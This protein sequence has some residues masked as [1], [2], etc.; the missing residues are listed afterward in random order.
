[1]GIIARQGIKQ[2]IV[3]YLGI[4][5]GAVNILFIYPK[6]L[7]GEQYGFIQALISAAKIFLPFVLL[8]SMY[9]IVRFFPDFKDKQNGHN[10]Y[11]PFILLW[12]NVGFTLFAAIFIGFQKEIF[13]IFKANQDMVA[14]YGNYLLPILYFLAIATILTKYI[15]NF[16]RIAIPSIF[17]DLFLK[18]GAP[19]LCILF[20]FQLLD[21]GNL[22]QGYAW[23][24]G[25]IVIALVYYTYYLGQLFLKLDFKKFTRE[26]L[27][28]IGTYASYGILGGL[29]TSIIPHIDNLMVASLMDFE[30]TAIYIIPNFITSAIDAPRRAIVGIAAPLIAESWKKNDLKHIQE[31]YQK[32]SLN[33][34][35]VGVFLLLLA[36]SSIDHLYTLIPEGPNKTNYEAG[37]YIVLI[38][39]LSKVF[40]MVTGVNSEIIG[41][42]KYFRFNFYAIVLL[43]VFAI[44]AN[45]FLIPIYG[46]KGAALATL[47]SYAIFNLIKFVFLLYKL[48]LQPFTWQTLQVIILGIVIYFIVYYAPDLSGL[49]PAI[50]FKNIIA[51]LLNIAF[52]SIAI[53]LLFGGAV[54]YFR[55]SEDISSLVGTFWKKKFGEK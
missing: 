48:N 54:L 41:Y 25:I 49:I 27:K 53:A 55:L 22:L 38:L 24:Y 5:I 32:T 8:G 9:M 37:K 11:L 31:L 30:N 16:H 23:L 21:F 36:W 39:G 28:S 33:Q 1:M 29:G 3:T 13:S 14:D 42:S 43:S 34:L 18:I 10:G 51:A 26:K 46:I 6:M 4:A 40:D 7:E 45:Y 15:S 17:N 2:S 12:G 20:G 44:L 35:I 47:I 52:K 19:I 50:D